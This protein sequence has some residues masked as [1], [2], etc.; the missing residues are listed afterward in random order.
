MCPP[1][2]R[3]YTSEDYL[4]QYLDKYAREMAEKR[5]EYPPHLMV[6]YAKPKAPKTKRAWVSPYPPETERLLLKLPVKQSKKI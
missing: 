1:K 3:K 2:P 4:N 6:F 5:T